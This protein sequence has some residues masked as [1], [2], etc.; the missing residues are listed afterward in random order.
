MSNH[1][2]DDLIRVINANTFSD[3]AHGAGHRIVLA[4]KRAGPYK[5]SLFGSLLE[6]RGAVHYFVKQWS[7]PKE[8]K[9][10]QFHWS[11]GTNAISLDFESSFVI[12]ANE[13]TQAYRLV[14]ALSSAVNPGE[15]LYELV[16]STI[17]TE[18]NQLLDDSNRKAINLL[19]I[20]KRSSIGIGESEELN[21]RVGERVRTALGG[22]VFRIGLQLRNAPPMQVEVARTGN[23]ADVFT[24][25]DSRSP[26]KAETTALL[27]LDN[28]QLFKKSG[29]HSEDDVRTAIGRAIT[30]AVKELLF[31]RKY[32]DVVR[33]FTRGEDPIEKQMRRRIEDEARTIGFSVKMFQSL[34]D[35]AALRLLEPVR[36]DIAAEEKYDL[37]NAVGYVQFSVSLMT[38]LGVDISRLHLLIDPDAEDVV[39]PIAARV[40]QIC[41][42]T[43]QRFDHQA[44]NLRF[45]TEVEPTLRQ[46]ICDGLVDCGLSS[47]IIHIS[48]APT[49][50]A[51]RFKAIR[52]RTIDFEALIR[53]MAN[54]GQADAVPTAGTIEVVSMLPSGWES[55]QSKDFGYRADSAMTELR[56]RALAEQLQVQVPS[57]GWSN[58]ERRSIA[59]D[60]E[61]AEIRQR[62]RNVLEAKMSMGQ[63][64]AEHWTTEKHS[65]LISDWATHLTTQAIGDEFGLM[66]EMRA[67]RRLE[68]ETEVTA[69]I[70]RET[71]HAVVRTAARGDAE[72]ALAHERRER[73][74]LDTNH[75]ELLKS[76][77]RRERDALDDPDSEEG[78]QVAE[79][80]R[81]DVK[82]GSRRPRP[83]SDRALEA[84]APRSN[85]TRTTAQLPW[86]PE[87]TSSREA[88]P[89]ETPE[90]S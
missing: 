67:F 80:L 38:Q 52:G 71:H 70:T 63:D 39:K 57:S 15:A 23:N 58:A 64:L 36:V 35:I 62:A 25:A 82:E 59:V 34:P 13:D 73:D 42:D 48:Q 19:D 31:A 68:T 12:Q 86:M 65:K 3:S 45:E 16:N 33:A 72:S 66:I 21:L 54:R 55:F 47:Q 29:L 28:Y 18:L 6:P 89:G 37:K 87:E 32:Y 77:G 22:A 20:F 11:E 74:V 90:A 27:H 17:S 56:M 40:R 24:L 2:I 49:E 1:A 79:Q 41:R 88:E 76:L 9:G 4:D 7:V 81:R 51:L 5:K 78:R 26:R 84:L 10:W 44:F 8:V 50:D 69:Q 30:S 53:P 83:T 46:S 61:M 85:P 14:E 75:I 43:M 60:L